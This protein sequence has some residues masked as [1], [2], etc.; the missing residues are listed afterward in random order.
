MLVRRKKVA[1]LSS[2]DDYYIVF[3]PFDHTAVLFYE[4]NNEIEV[5]AR[6]R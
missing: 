4:F 5:L 1:Y 3:L 6:N 2:L